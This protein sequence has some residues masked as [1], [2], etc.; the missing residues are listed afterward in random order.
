MV[1]CG[2]DTAVAVRD[3][4]TGEGIATLSGHV[5]RV[6]AV[7]VTPDGRTIVSAGD[8]GTA[9]LWDLVTTGVPSLP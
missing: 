9:R 6:V 7:D 2:D 3:A 1:T 4:T 8:D 5:D